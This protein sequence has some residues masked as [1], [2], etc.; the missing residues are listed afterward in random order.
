[1]N[2]PALRHALA[3]L[4]GPGETV[5]LDERHAVEMTGED[6]RGEETGDA[7]AGHHRVAK[8]TVRHASLLSGRR[9][10]YRLWIPRASATSRARRDP[11]ALLLR[12]SWREEPAI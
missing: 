4:R 12:G 11:C 8:R 3:R 1:M 9:Q 6:A 2:V 10:P 7:A 5:A